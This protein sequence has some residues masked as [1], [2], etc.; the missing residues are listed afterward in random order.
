MKFVQTELGL[1]VPDEG[2]ERARKHGIVWLDHLET[3]LLCLP[4]GFMPFEQVYEPGPPTA[5]QEGLTES[6][7][8]HLRKLAPRLPRTVSNIFVGR[9]G[10]LFGIGQTPLDPKAKEDIFI[11]V[12]RL[13]YYC[14]KREGADWSGRS[15]LRT[16]YKNWLIG[17]KILRLSAQIIERNG[18]GIPTVYYNADKVSK[19]DAEQIVQD[20]RAGATAGAAL[21]DGGAKLELTGVTGQ[22]VDPLPHM[23]YHDEKIAESALAMFKTLGHDSGARSLGDTFV[24]IFTQAVQSIANY[25]AR[26][27]TEHIIR[28]LVELNFGPDEPYPTLTAGDLSANR[29]IT[30]TAIKELVDAKIIQ[31]DD[32]LEA[33]MRKTH[34]LPEIDA[35]TA[36][37]GE[38]DPSADTLAKANA[39]GALIRSGY[40]PTEAADAAGLEPIKHLG[41]L[42][43]TVQPP[44]AGTDL[45]NAPPPVPGTP[46]A[47]DAAP[48]TAALAEGDNT[49]S[50]P[51]SKRSCLTSRSTEP[52]SMCSKCDTLEADLTV[53]VLL[54]EAEHA[55]ILAQ[56]DAG[57]SVP[58]A[59]R[60][61]SAAE[62][63]AKMR[64]SEIEALE[65]SAAEKAAKLLASNAQLYVMAVIGAI[66]GAEDA[67][68]P[69]AVVDAV[70]TLNRA[71]PADVIAETAR[72][73]KVMSSILSAVYTGAAEIVIGEALRQGVKAVPKPLKAEPDRFDQ[74]AKA[75]SLHP[76]TR[77]T[78][79]LQA[80][81]L[82]P[83]TLGLPAIAK[84][85]V[86]KALTEI[87]IDGAVDLAKQTIH[88]AH[89]AG[90][91]EA[92]ET[93]QPEEIYSSELMDG[94]TCPA[95]AKVDGKDYETM[96]EAKVE[97]EAGGYGACAGGARC[98]GTLVFQYNGL[99]IDAPPAP[100]EPSP[101]PVLVPPVKPKTPRKRKPATPPPA[102]PAPVLPDVIANPPLTRRQALELERQNAAK[103]KAD[104][105]PG[106]PP[107][108][109]GTPPKRRKGTSQRYEAL[110]QL[111]VDKYID[112]K[113]FTKP[114]DALIEAKFMNPGYAASNG[115]DKNY[116]NNC[117]SVVSAYEMRRRGYD[118]RAAPVKGGKGRYDEQY[119]GDWWQDADGN[120]VKVTYAKELPPL[121]VKTHPDGSRIKP[122]NAETKAKLDEYIESQPDGARGFVALHWEKGGGH[123]F[124]WEKIDGK[125]V[126]LEGQNGVAD[127]S[128]HLAV[129][130]FKSPSVRIVRIDDKI[131][132]NAVTEALETRPDELA[133]ELKATAEKKAA[134]GPT[135][136]EKK[137]MSQ[138]YLRT[139]PN[140][141]SE[142]IP[143]YWRISKQNGRY[144]EVPQAERQKLIDEWAIKQAERLVARKK[145]GR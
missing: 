31:P 96:T 133:G 141:T 139:L 40:D 63:K 99:G 118:V 119:V 20:L 109:T 144:E 37:S 54:A 125:P 71:Q 39:A 68:A 73:Q 142:L 5:E 41:L 84:A 78:G 67:V 3:A 43:V 121:K 83:R 65:R 126:Y 115:T 81:M 85:D 130:K 2:L 106:L 45:D 38:G 92:A 140:G 11:P 79:K 134:A 74:L 49:R 138:T 127:A 76:W 26:T 107:A 137:K 48:A 19:A 82:E 51:G 24:D 6:M 30:T 36:R 9:D 13:V 80:D 53:E 23:K 28:D 135:S 102:P 35:A 91:V 18:M 97:Y 104:A 55:L 93:M 112:T 4:F 88:T 70:E 86:E 72:S 61:L 50:C 7:L 64:F 16:V 17:D 60:P 42:P 77:I 108:P 46:S 14:H 95:C 122:G 34:G 44:A 117:S 136:A 101:I 143:P 1:D 59:I 110:D 27:A 129:G 94:A 113:P 21:P 15:V 33:F 10:G 58:G 66:F 120:P 89:G 56:T 8:L 90:R 111:P 114:N 52:G 32:K 105:P 145:M 22:T 25:F 75:V 116:S 103:A 128:R 123:V 132:T 69:A 12:E 124:N 62:R 57:E 47:P 100:P 87:P 131:P 29:A 98:R